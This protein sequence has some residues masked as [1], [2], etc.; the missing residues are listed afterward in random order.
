MN[1]NARNIAVSLFA[2]VAVVALAACGQKPSESAAGDTAA[3]PEQASP[4]AAAKASKRDY[5]SGIFEH[6]AAV[7]LRQG[8]N[9]TL[10]RVNKKPVG[11]MPYVSG[12]EVL[13]AGW[14]VAPRGTGVS[15]PL[16]VLDGGGR[17]FAHEFKTGGKRE[18]VARQLKRPDAANAGYNSKVVL[19]GVPEGDYAVWLVQEGDGGFRCDT[20]KS[21]TITR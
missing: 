7:E 19:A 11:A 9:C 15:Q 16:L 18:D 2:V 20:K 21:I 10:D 17:Q 4:A 14:F 13:F 1:S 5:P 6:A 12:E 8:G 3:G